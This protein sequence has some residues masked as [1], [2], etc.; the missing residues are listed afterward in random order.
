ML[1]RSQTL[2][3]SL[4]R[5]K[6]GREICPKSIRNEG[7]EVN[8]REGL[9]IELGGL[10]SHSHSPSHPTFPCSKADRNQADSRKNMWLTNT[11]LKMF[12][13]TYNPGYVIN[14]IS[15]ILEAGV[16]SSLVESGVCTSWGSSLKTERSWKEIAILPD[17]GTKSHFGKF[18]WSLCK[19]ICRYLLGS[20]KD[21]GKWG[22]WSRSLMGFRIN[23]AFLGRVLNTRDVARNMLNEFTFVHL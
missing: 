10:S 11:T 15:Y 6:D 20:W 16:K 22:P 8:S 19:Y 9:G 17:Y 2:C 23:P 5:C 7:E 1:L 4:S 13:F 21:P 3:L 12:W 14:L 18:F